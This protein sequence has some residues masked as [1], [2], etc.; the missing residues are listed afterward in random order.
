MTRRHLFL[1]ISTLALAAGA[2]NAQNT[3]TINS[4]GTGNTQACNNTGTAG[5][6][7]TIT[8]SGNGND[9][10]VN[11]SGGTYFQTYNQNTGTYTQ[12]FQTSTRNTGI[13]RQFGNN[14]DAVINQNDGNDNFGRLIQ[15]SAGAQANNNSSTLTQSGFLNTATVTQN[16]AYSVSN[17][18]QSGGARDPASTTGGSL[19]GSGNSVVVTQ[20]STAT[21]AGA[22]F[23]G[24]GFSNYN[25]VVQN[26]RS[27]S[28]G[29]TQNGRDQ[30]AIVVQGDPFAGTDARRNSATITQSGS[31]GGAVIDQRASGTDGDTRV[32]DNIADIGQN[33]E[34]STGTGFGSFSNVGYVIQRS[35]GNNGLIRM[36]GGTN[37]AGTGTSDANTRNFAVITQSNTAQS[38]TVLSNNVARVFLGRGD[39]LTSNVTQNGRNNFAEVT[40]A[41]GVAGANANVQGGRSTGNSSTVN[42]TSTGAAAG[43]S[44]GSVAI[45]VAQ[46]ARGQTGQGIGN[47]STIN[48]NSTA[49]FAAPT[50]GVTTFNSTSET[51]FFPGSRGQ[52]AVV[53]Q[54][55]QFANATV[56]QADNA[57]SGRTFSSG[58][59]R[60]RAQVFQVGRLMSAT[61]NQT[62]DNFADVTQGRLGVDERG[63]LTLNQT[64]AGDT[65]SAGGGFDPQGNPVSNNNRQSN[66]ATIVQYGG[67]STAGA[68]TIFAQQN[69][70]GGRITVFQQGTNGTTTATS[71]NNNVDVQQGTGSTG[72]FNAD[73]PSTISA[74]PATGANTIGLTANITQGGRNNGLRV[75]Q[76]GTNLT[77][78]VQQL[79]TGTGTPIAADAG[80]AAGGTQGNNA[81]SGN[82][83]QVVQQGSGNSA[84]AIQTSTATQ[85]AC[86]TDA[87]TNCPASGTGTGAAAPGQPGTITQGTVRSAEIAILQSG[88]INPSTGA[89]VGNR[90]YAEQ[91]G[92]GQNAR[93]EQRGFG[94]TAGILQ[95]TGANNATARITQT[96]NNNSYFV[97]QT[98]PGEFISVVQAGN[99]NTANTVD[100]SGAAGSGSFNGTNRPANFPTT[101]GF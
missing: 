11:Q 6:I 62:G 3:N 101:N 41:S 54:Q 47:V 85:S 63:T 32:T 38:S 95:D 24:T 23:R 98:A 87:A 20:N 48:Q 55:G 51:A 9:A 42:Q 80:S 74:A 16:G 100:Q 94:N 72:F 30:V 99:S 36:T 5:N 52:Y 1:G 75:R 84:T 57:D 33:S 12:T 83:I 4:S 31:F 25:R 88:G 58:V 96:G 59:A 73:S 17:V 26:G 29:V 46:A 53:Y 90:A 79:G 50:G 68:G 39:Q 60:A 7:C 78:N 21:D 93:I 64:D 37:A 15:G 35:S 77:A 28:T 56:T 22:N 97:I 40:L 65:T 27:N 61:V 49:N 71:R 69:T 18:S 92:R 67:D 91:R 66:T 44:G 19:A 81:N 86:G 45:V 43:T 10:T 2:A 14:N 89:I 8:Q 76:D 13:I 34:N 82:I 70:L